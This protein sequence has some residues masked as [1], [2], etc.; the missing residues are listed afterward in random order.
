MTKDVKKKNCFV[1]M[2]FS[3]KGG[4]PDEKY[5]TEHFEK[6]LKPIIEE[7]ELLEAKRANSLREDIVR[8]I[9][10]NLYNS[11]IVVAEL[12]DFN[13]NVYW[14]LGVRQSFKHGT[15]TIAE[16]GTKIPF[17]IST[18]GTL[19]YQKDKLKDKKFKNK[20]TE[21]LDDCLKNPNHPD[22]IVL[23]SI[24][25]RGTLFQLFLREET[26]RRLD[27]L[28]YDCRWNEKILDISYK[29]ALL[30]K[31]KKFKTSYLATVPIARLSG[32]DLLLTNRYIDVKDEFYELATTYWVIINGLNK[33]LELWGNNPSSTV[34]DL[35]KLIPDSKKVGEEFK[36]QVKKIRNDLK[37]GDEK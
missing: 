10:H 7:N 22:S 14:E 20:F 15:I 30:Y 13:P 35:I 5:W 23:E 27:G 1:I 32:I 4:E 12:T 3:N 24:G 17:N 28:I 29:N 8:E 6:F 2:P 33:K 19:T 9:L 21:A 26:I 34:K 18:K 36:G 16:E 31:S 25:G 11:P 37:N